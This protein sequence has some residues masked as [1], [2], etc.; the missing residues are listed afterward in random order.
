MKLSG[1]FN[2]TKTSYMLKDQAEFVFSSHDHFNMLQDL[3]TDTSECQHCICIIAPI[4]CPL[5]Q[6]RECSSYLYT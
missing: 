1:C 3:K 2:G 6:Y 4:Y 5:W